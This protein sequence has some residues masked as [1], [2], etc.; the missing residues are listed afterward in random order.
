M[1]FESTPKAFANFASSE[2]FGIDAVLINA[3]GVR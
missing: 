2:G 1:Q 3:E